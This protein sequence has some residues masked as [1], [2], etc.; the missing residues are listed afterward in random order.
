VVSG[1]VGNKC[2]TFPL[3][4]LGFDVDPINSVQFSNH[5]GYKNGVKGQVLNASELEDLYQ[6]L[7]QNNL[8]YSYTHLLT[9]YCGND[10]F[11]R[12][13]KEII[14][15]LREA[16]PNITYVC[17]PVMGDSIDG[18]GF[19]YVPKELL[20]IYRDEI[21]PLA[22]IITP[23]Q[24]EVEMLTETKITSEE[25]AWNALEFFHQKG[26]KVVVM[27]S[28]EFAG[29]DVLVAYMSVKS[30]T[31]FETVNEKYKL[32]I[33]NQSGYIRF[34]GVGDLFAAIFLANVANNPGKYGKALE[35]TVA[36][37]QSVI[38]YTLESLTEDERSG[39]T[40]VT[41][42][43]KELKIVQCK[44]HIE[45]PVIKLNAIRID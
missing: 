25:E 23:N 37:L 39:K 21:I 17:D 7:E 26:V 13:I 11:L 44:K 12:Q 16:N 27:S 2:A 35:L 34:T 42:H 9:G 32:S 30:P 45:N 1:Y 20:P 3:Q 40:K 29:T 4:C 8:Q 19:M 31:E 33:P 24:Y 5:T 22:D 28:S 10:T 38:L 41:A 14:K 43:R 36:S 6:G 15:R 18:K